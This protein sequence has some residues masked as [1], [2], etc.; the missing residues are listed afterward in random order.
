MREK[1]RERERERENRD[2]RERTETVVCIYVL[3][4]ERATHLIWAG[5][6]RVLSEHCRVYMCAGRGA[7]DPPDMGW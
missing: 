2:G 5:D 7:D 4:E 3:A 1:W 6:G